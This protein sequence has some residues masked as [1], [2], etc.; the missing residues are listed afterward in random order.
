MNC[1]QC[2]IRKYTY[3]MSCPACRNRLAMAFF[4]KILR[5]EVVRSNEKWGETKDWQK[6]P[7]C[8]CKDQCVM[9]SRIKI[10]ESQLGSQAIN[11]S[12]RKRY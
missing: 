12:N 2:F 4:C 6:E 8:G 3:N 11:K 7:H 5:A 10:D 1:P 9:K